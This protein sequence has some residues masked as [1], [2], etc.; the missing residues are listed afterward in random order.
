VPVNDT[1]NI[2]GSGANPPTC[3]SFT[4]VTSLEPLSA[5]AGAPGDFFGPGRTAG[6]PFGAQIADASLSRVRRAARTNLGR[7]ALRVATE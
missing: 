3:S 7:G 2:T 1:S 6:G 5:P 4:P